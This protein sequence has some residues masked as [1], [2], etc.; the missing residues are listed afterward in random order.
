MLL[1][2][3][4]A[5]LADLESNLWEFADLESNFWEFA[6]LECTPIAVSR[7][8]VRFPFSLNRFKNT[9][10]LHVYLFIDAQVKLCL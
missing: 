8:S 3:D 2:S 1:F 10:E 7:P 4:K 5:R 6:D 9:V